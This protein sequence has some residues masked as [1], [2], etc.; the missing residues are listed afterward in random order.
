LKAIYE[1]NNRVTN[2]EIIFEPAYYLTAGAR[3]NSIEIIKMLRPDG[4]ILEYSDN[5]AELLKM[6]IP[7]VQTNSLNNHEAVIGTIGNYW[8]DGKMA[9]DYFVSLG[10]RQLGF[11]GADYVNFSQERFKSLK[12][13]AQQQGIPVFSH[14]ISQ[15]HG[16][17]EYERNLHNLIAWLKTLPTPVGIL[18]ACDDFGRIL[19]NACAAAGLNVPNQ[20]AVLGVD[21]D[22]LLC[23]LCVPSLSS[24]SRKMAAAAAEMCSILSKLMSGRTVDTEFVRV[25]PLEV[26]VRASTD[27]LATTEEAVAQSIAFISENLHLPITVEDVVNSTGISRRTLYAKFK[28]VTGNSI[29]KEIQMRKLQKFKHLLE[30]EDLSIKEIAAQLGFDEVAHVSRWFASLEGMPP[31]RWKMEVRGKRAAPIQQPP[32]T[33]QTLPSS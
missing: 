18:A 15:H 9:F 29:Q 24:I 32:W 10:F 23:N 7:V 20:V 22:E 4:C 30:E 14:H 2:W 33:S 6:D 21:N 8:L 25:D 19:I 31:S 1:Y 12:A 28:K 5:V 13:H 11:F 26:V 3:T 17:F 27:T 16:P